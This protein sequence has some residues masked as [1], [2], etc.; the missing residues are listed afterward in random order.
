MDQSSVSSP[1]TKLAIAWGGVGMSFTFSWGEFAAM[2]ASLYTTLLIGEWL[3][4]HGA[5]KLLEKLGW[6]KELPPKA[7]KAP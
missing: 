1:V 3:W 2:L 6:L 7:P 5:R 4:K